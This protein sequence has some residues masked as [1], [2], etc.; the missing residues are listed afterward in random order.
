[1]SSYISKLDSSTLG[2]LPY[3]S[4]H[5][6]AFHQISLGILDESSLSTLDCTFGAGHRGSW[7]PRRRVEDDLTQPGDGRG[8]PR[9]RSTRCGMRRRPLRRC[10]SS[11]RAAGAAPG[12]AGRRGITSRVSPHPGQ[13]C[14]LA[15]LPGDTVRELD[16]ADVFGRP[17]P[18]KLARNPVL[19]RE[20]Q[21]RLEKRWSPEQISRSLR[22][23]LLIRRRW[24]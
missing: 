22:R 24:G 20:V 6:C 10:R 3:L 13:A 15:G 11:C 19:L 4:D 8:R 12:M 9:R 17:K 2:A 1:V 16:V 5:R 7:P 23:G 18:R 21:V 14:S